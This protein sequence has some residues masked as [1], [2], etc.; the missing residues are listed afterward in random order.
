MEP[1]KGV[2]GAA[3]L[4]TAWS[5]TSGC[6]NDLDNCLILSGGDMWTGPAISTLTAGKSM[7]DV[8]NAMGYKA[9]ALGNH[10]FDFGLEN[11]T[12]RCSEMKFPLLAANVKFKD[13]HQLPD[14]IQPYT[15]ID[16]NHVSVGVLGLASVQRSLS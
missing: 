6:G 4:M 12:T 13:T 2:G 8:M 7:A 11:I 3:S 9:A 10:E 14:F 16:I 1:H 15:I 5:V